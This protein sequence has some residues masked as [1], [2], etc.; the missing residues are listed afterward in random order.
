MTEDYD[1]AL[2]P[3]QTHIIARAANEGIPLQAIGR[4]LRVPFESVT[5]AAKIALAAGTIIGMPRADW[6]AAEHWDQRSP[7]PF[8]GKRDN[9]QELEFSCRQ[10]FRLTALETGFI[11]S[12]L[13]RTFADKEK[14]HGVI[15]DQRLKRQS[16]PDA[17]TTDPK[18]VDV[19]ICKLRKKLDDKGFKGAIQT[20]WGRGYFIEPDTKR[21]IYAAIGLEQGQVEPGAERANVAA[22][23]A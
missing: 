10:F 11:V 16:R 21:A 13:R 3:E 7:A 5:H 2:S 8:V 19:M 23:S 18:M 14:L 1:P 15:E 17:E 12:L 4:I 9:T 20:M 22:A 6:P